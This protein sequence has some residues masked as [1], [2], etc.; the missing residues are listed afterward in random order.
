MPYKLYID[1]RYREAN[2]PGST[3]TNFVVQ[4]PEPLQ[5]KGK[6]IIDAV[7]FPNSFYTIRTGDNDRVFVK[8][9]VGGVDVF[10]VITL[11]PSPLN[12]F[13]L[14]DALLLALQ[15]GKTIGGD[16]VCTYLTP[17]GQI[18]VGNLDLVD[19]FTLYPSAALQDTMWAGPPLD[20]NNLMGSDAVLGLSSSASP[21]V[22][23]SG[24][25]VVFADPVNVQPYHH[26][27]LRSNSLGTGHDVLGNV[28]GSSDI[29]RRVIVGSTPLNG[30]CVDLHS[31]PYD[32]VMIGG[33]K[34]ISSL[35]FRLTDYKGK[36][37]NLR[38]H[39]LSFSIIFVDLDE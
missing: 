33:T 7:L 12:A 9:T 10:R 16:Y 2:T 32:A 27:F 20:V 17:T 21:L 25:A 28:P 15:S 37:V 36:I 34:E 22:V 23:P 26:L 35:E 1:S 18:Q 38:N 24:I 8:E 6:A 3:D 13:T 5:V 39:P 14:K 29:V 11:E 30:M 19:G 4:L 31:L